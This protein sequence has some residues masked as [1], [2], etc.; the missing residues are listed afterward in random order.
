M[1]LEKLEK[2]LSVIPDGNRTVVVRVHNGLSDFELEVTAVETG[3]N[4]VVLLV[5]EADNVPLDGNLDLIDAISK[6]IGSIGIIKD[7][8]A[9]GA[10]KECP[11]CCIK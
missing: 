8:A 6:K 4:K 11:V 10:G 1:T 9:V 2:E 5:G 7:V 3:D